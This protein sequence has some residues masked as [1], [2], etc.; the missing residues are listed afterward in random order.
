MAALATMTLVEMNRDHKKVFPLFKK[1][2]S[3]QSVPIP[4]YS[5]TS[6]ISSL[7]QQ[8]PHTPEPEHDAESPLERY[9]SDENNK[10]ISDEPTSLQFP[11]TTKDATDGPVQ[12]TLLEVDLNEGRRKR[13][14]T[15]SPEIKATS[16]QPVDNDVVEIVKPRTKAKGSRKS[17]VK[18]VEC[19]PGSGPE[20]LKRA[21]PDIPD[22]TLVPPKGVALNHAHSAKYQKRLGKQISS[23]HSRP[24][25]LSQDVNSRS[26]KNSLEQHQ[27]AQK[28]SDIGNGIIGLAHTKGDVGF[29]VGGKP[30]K[31]LQWNPKTG[32]IGSPPKTAVALESGSKKAKAAAVKSRTILISYGKGSRLPADIGSKIENILNNV[33]TFVEGSKA[34]KTVQNH[35]ADVSAKPTK[36]LHPLFGG[37]QP[38]KYKNK[39]EACEPPSVACISKLQKSKPS[40]RSGMVS[41][42]RSSSP[43]KRAS[44]AVFG[45]SNG[46]LRFPG[47]VEPAWPWAGM[48]HIRGTDYENH[49]LRARNP[50]TF[51]ARR[52][53]KK[54]KYQAV[55]IPDRERIISVLSSKLDVKAVAKVV[56]E[57]K[58]D[59]FPTVPQCLRIPTKHYEG[60]SALRRRVI[61]ETCSLLKGNNPLLKGAI[62]EDEDVSPAPPAPPVHPAISRVYNAVP[63]TLSAFDQGNCEPQAWTQKYAPKFAS[64]ILQQ[65]REPLMLKTWLQTLIIQSVDTGGVTNGPALVRAGKRKRKVRKEDKFIVSSDDEDNDLDQITDLEDDL[66]VSGV[67]TSFKKT[68]IRN[69]DAA[70]MGS[71]DSTRLTNAVVLSGPHGCGKTA[72]VYAIAN[73]LG[74]EVFEINPGSRRSGKDILE[75]VGDMTRNHQVQQSHHPAMVDEDNIRLDQALAQDLDSGRQGTMDSFFK[76]KSRPQAKAPSSKHTVASKKTGSIGVMGASKRPLKQQKQSLI[77]IEEADIIFDE[78]KQFW[79]TTISLLAQSKRPIIITCNDEHSIPFQALSLHGI[80]RFQP[81]PADLAVD[82]MLLVAACEGHALRREA[83]SSLFR[84]RKFDLRA[85]IMDMNFWC[86]FAVGD[87]KN[88]LDWFYPRWPVGKDVDDR[89]ETIRVVSEGTYQAGMGGLGQDN[90]ESRCHI[91]D[92]EEEILHQAWDTRNIDVGD[93]HE[94]I[95]LQAWG[96]KVQASSRGP[97]DDRSALEMYENFTESM[98]VADISSGT[99]FAPDNQ[100]S[101]FVCFKNL[102]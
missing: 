38:T 13:R 89:G 2:S 50:G 10:T 66:E 68:V 40:G 79:Q 59:E 3:P 30:K 63:A 78:D 65:G 64:E 17:K 80:F 15:F 46:V 85:S 6:L 69:G 94:T 82:Y 34:K 75:K 73:E 81:P 16:P 43:P 84:S 14:K 9:A 72:T 1:P 31:M 23:A 83:V 53:E 21:I 22:S 54:S 36:L 99:A 70:A 101:I 88:G 37:K 92:I 55:Q 29:G 19:A 71:K 87:V 62:N 32:T 45:G 67:T 60:G 102:H 93:W 11:P 35:P 61:R 51:H 24:I 86:Q 7:E 76:T 4:S 5:Y 56:S 98:S 42:E 58:P 33:P 8:K 52:N 48:L 90:L 39:N 49:R 27:E 28:P 12:A 25:D 100:V 74:F 41:H 77:L 44:L 97:L 26:L 95:D 57:T 47:A 91:L 96:S 18:Q 20:S